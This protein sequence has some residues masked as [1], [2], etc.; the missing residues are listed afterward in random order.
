[1]PSELPEEDD[2]AKILDVDVI[3][4]PALSVAVFLNLT[5]FGQS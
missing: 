4:A 3:T 1:M 2:M 5:K